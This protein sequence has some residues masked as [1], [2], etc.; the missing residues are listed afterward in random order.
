VQTGTEQ[1]LI[2]AVLARRLD[3]ALAV[4]P[5]NHP[6]LVE[7]YIG[8]EELVL[9]TAPG[10]GDP[11]VRLRETTDLKILVLRRGCAYRQRLEDLLARRGVV[12]VRC[13]EFGMLDAI[14]GCVA[15][16]I[17]IT[18]LPRSVAD[19]ARLDGCIAVHSLPPEE[20]LVRS[21]FIRRAD[22]FASSALQRFLECVRQHA[23]ATG[24]LPAARTS[25]AAGVLYRTLESSGSPY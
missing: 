7:D 9:V 16:G 22:A 13:M 12:N 25:A 5:V 1:E 21:V 19:P 6:Q 17:G 8:Q 10:W 14:L 23:V 24:W 11:E 4:G 3:C 20:A 18:L 2:E 15:A